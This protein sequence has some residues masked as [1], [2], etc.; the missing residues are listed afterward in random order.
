[1]KKKADSIR[2]VLGFI[3][4]GILSTRTDA[5]GVIK[6]GFYK[7][8]NVADHSV[9]KYFSSITSHHKIVKREKLKKVSS[10]GLECHF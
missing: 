7:V 4:I 9:T 2:I 10:T 8:E 6:G 3:A 5:K 1:M